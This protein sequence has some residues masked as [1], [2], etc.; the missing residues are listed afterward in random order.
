MR[1]EIVHVLRGHLVVFGAMTV[2]DFVW[3]EYNK[4]CARGRLLYAPATSSVIILLS[5]FTIR[6]FVEDA[7]FLLT[8]ALGAFVGTFLSMRYGSKP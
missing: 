3:A 2:L 4:A 5:G 7:S 1:S 8:C 6:S